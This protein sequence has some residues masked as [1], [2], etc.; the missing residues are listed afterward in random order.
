MVRFK[1][2]LD[3]KQEIPCISYRACAAKTTADGQAGISVQEHCEYVGEVAAALIRRLPGAVR[4]QIPDNVVSLIALHDVGKVSPGFQRK[5][6]KEML[7]R[8]SPTLYRYDSTNF[9]D[10]HAE[11]SEAS[12]K[13]W[14]KDHQN[15]N[16][17][18]E[19]WGEVLG[20]HHGIR[21]IPSADGID[22]Y[23]GLSWQ[24][25]RH[26]LIAVLLKR[27][28]P[29]PNSRPASQ[30]QLQIIS[31]LTC[32]ADWIASDEEFFPSQGL[33][34]GTDVQQQAE[35]ALD[36]SGW[37]FPSIKQGM[38]FRDIFGFDEPNAIQS[39]L[40]ESV[41]EPGLYILEAPMGHGKTEAA[42][43]AAYQL[44]AAGH[45]S[46]FY[47]GLPTRLTSERIHER[48][49]PFLHAVAEETSKAR[50]IHGQAW[51]RAGGEEFRSGK[52]W[53]NPRKRALLL[54]FGVGTVDQALLSV[55][56]VKHNFV[57]TFGLAGKVVIL[58][59]VHT[60]DV[61][62]GTLLDELVKSLLAMGC[63]VI[64]LS[65]TLTRER[66]A[67][68]FLHNDMPE[69]ESYPLITIQGRAKK[70][71]TIATAPPP[72]RRVDI[73]M[74]TDNVAQI[75]QTA[76]ERARQGQ[77]VLWI[78]NTVAASQAYYK[79]VK[80]E[81]V[82]DEFKVGLL[83]SCFPAFR[84][85]E[86]ESEW[87]SGLG[88][89]GTRPKGCIL[90]ATQV[91]EQSV[92]I[93]A[94][95]LITE[96]APT[97]MLLQRIGRLWRHDRK[98]R[99]CEK[100]E[101]LIVVGDVEGVQDRQMLK[102]A[103]GDSGYIYAPYVLWRTFHV[104]SGRTDVLL[105]D[106]IRTLLET[107]YRDPEQDE[108]DFIREVRKKLEKDRADLRDIALGM[109]A[110][111]N[112]QMKDNEY[113]PTRYNTQREVQV[114]L[115]RDLQSTIAKADL[116]LADGQHVSVDEN[117]RDFDTTKKLHKN[118]VSVVSYLL[119]PMPKPPP[120]LRKHIYGDVAVL[121]IGEDGQL[122]DE[123][124]TP[125]PLGYDN[126]K[127]IYKIE[128]EALRRVRFNDQEEEYYESDW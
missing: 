113:V 108:P 80:S 91:V 85:E 86:L 35:L 50:L 49:N 32:V 24:K 121:R 15:G 4:R 78:A 7:R 46:G 81:M 111:S 43:Y 114:L 38:S 67:A 11:I 68:F 100:P 61:Y 31:G 18:V 124:G 99:P 95:F 109:T 77:C 36:Q 69:D 71:Q 84:R 116:T 26:K 118:L 53:F 10:N 101:V 45:N 93:D 48:V 47:F 110:E 40:L 34:D 87:M 52:A 106:E 22:P 128:D 13:S 127:G 59:E 44:V 3:K 96:L 27:F 41:K 74:T 119:S 117:E 98:N 14:L 2:L 5:Y 94:D 19:R 64:V 23:G 120:Y 125:M 60:Y 88:K 62:T 42:L 103:L 105:P 76:V 70:I 89:D 79:A 25:E 97:D 115:V 51:L 33:P 1:D 55:L 112:P 63:S 21:D 107:T 9:K 104:W 56:R 90:V 122:S 30:Q 6:F 102:D 37:V 28:G 12:L 57:R 92:D 65:A 123:G 16:P 82:E 72:S 39:A 66:R 17:D 58:D 29:L 126:E 83:H 75:A 20:S 8:L 73:S 54:P